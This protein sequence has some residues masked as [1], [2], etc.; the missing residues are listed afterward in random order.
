MHSENME[1]AHS[2]GMDSNPDFLHCETRVLTTTPHAA[3]L[4]D[5][6][7]KDVDCVSLRF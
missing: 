6:V 3:E 7:L 2:E 5:P 4:H 1:P